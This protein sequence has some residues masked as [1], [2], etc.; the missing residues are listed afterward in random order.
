MNKYSRCII[1]YNDYISIDKQETYNIDSFLNGFQQV[2]H[3]LGYT[4]PCK[5][6]PMFLRI[7]LNL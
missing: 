6:T 3:R 4:P 7:V 1:Y 2:I 5:V